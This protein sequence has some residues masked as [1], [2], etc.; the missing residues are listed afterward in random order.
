MKKLLA[1]IATALFAVVALAGCGSSTDTASSEKTVLKVG[2]TA[3]PHAEILEQ[4]KPELAKEG[5]DLQII[6]FNDY[7]QPNLA[8]NDGELDAYSKKV[9]ALD[10]LKDGALVAIPN[11][12]TNGGRALILM[13]KAG[14]ITLK[15]NNDIKATVQDVVANPKNI[16]FQEVEAAQLPRVL[17]DVDAAVI[18]TNYAMQAGFVPASDALIIE[19]ST[20]PYVNIVAV[21]EGDQEKPAIQKLMKALKSEAVKKFIEE[22]YKGA[23]VPAFE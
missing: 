14:I 3:V 11:D 22:K 4:I 17:D 20:S 10:E 23:V 13:A 2:A 9:K 21:R 5:V 12:P 19:D 1:V 6:E 18:N 15:D 8:L 16:Q 7:V